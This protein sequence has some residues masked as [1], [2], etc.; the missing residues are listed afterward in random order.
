MIIVKTKQQQKLL[1]RYKY[2]P[3]KR[4]QS[5]KLKSNLNIP[6]FNYVRAWIYT[7]KDIK[8]DPL[9]VEGTFKKPK[10]TK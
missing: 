4:L 5:I 6:F 10:D 3:N 2:N 7:K 8:D 9:I 1:K